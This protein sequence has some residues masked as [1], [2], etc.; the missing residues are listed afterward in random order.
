MAV[1]EI[2]VPASAPSTNGNAELP[3]QAWWIIEPVARALALAE[4]I[5]SHPERL[6]TG[7]TGE[8]RNAERHTA[9]EGIKAF[10]EHVNARTDVNGLAPI[11]SE[12]SPRTRRPAPAIAQSSNSSDPKH[13]PFCGRPDD[14]QQDHLGHDPRA[15]SARPWGGS[16]PGRNVDQG[17]R[18][19]E[20]R[21][22]DA[23]TH[24]RKW[25]EWNKP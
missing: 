6:F 17:F 15:S 8:V 23:L 24:C 11:P 13:G 1:A 21:I 12:R 5:S 7:I 22:A 14:D 16:W 18:Q 2:A 10:V 25:K 3:P 4:R 9:N 19:G 20:S